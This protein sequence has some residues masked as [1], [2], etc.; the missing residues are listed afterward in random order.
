VIPEPEFVTAREKRLVA[1][2]REFTMDT[3]SNIPALWED[4]WSR[5]WAFS[6]NEEQAS[7]GVSYGFSPDGRFS[8]AAGRH[9]APIPDQLPD[10]ACLVT[11][12]AG[13]YAVFHQRGPI[14]EIPALFDAIFQ[15]W[16][17]ASGETQRDSAVFE[18]YPYEDSASPAT[19]AYE[20]WVP[21]AG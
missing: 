15:D 20:I 1:L 4:F 17:P 7:F 13:R 11:L 10:G 2:S 21:L 8:Y 6:G 5:E 16:L 14:A 12:A 19:M 18:R 3:R 9:V